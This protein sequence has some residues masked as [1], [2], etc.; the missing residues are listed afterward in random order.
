[1]KPTGGDR[2]GERRPDDRQRTCEACATPWATTSAAIA[3]RPL[4]RRYPA[5]A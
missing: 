1:M 2:V 4:V 3:T 5:D